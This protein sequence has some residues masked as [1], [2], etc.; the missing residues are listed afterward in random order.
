MRPDN[1]NAWESYLWTAIQVIAYG[2][3]AF[4]LIWVWRKVQRAFH[5]GLH[6]DEEA[7]R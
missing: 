2:G 6:G 3:G 4:L 5:E 7:K 1:L